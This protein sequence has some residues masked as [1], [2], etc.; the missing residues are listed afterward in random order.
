MYCIFYKAVEELNDTIIDGKT[1]YVGRAQNKSK[2]QAELRE[3]YEEIRKNNIMQSEGFNVYVKNLDKSISDKRLRNE[4]S[5]FGTI[6][7]AKVCINCSS[8]FHTNF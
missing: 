6:S 5:Q 3:T 2:R 8:C 1:L 7:S 4:F